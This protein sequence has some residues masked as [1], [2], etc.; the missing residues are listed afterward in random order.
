VGGARLGQKDL[1]TRLTEAGEDALQRIS[2]LPGGNRAVSA[3][4]ELRANVDELG[5]KVR[6]IDRLE[7]RVAELEREVAALKRSKATPRRTSTTR[8]KTPPPSTA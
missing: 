8:T 6:G 5:K 2:E 4:N 1:V 7:E 3:F